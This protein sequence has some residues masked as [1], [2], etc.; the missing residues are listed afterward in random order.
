MI[1]AQIVILSGGAGTR[2]WPLSREA[3]PKQFHDFTGS[4][5][6]L[7]V[8]TLQ[9]LSA[10][11]RASV[12]TTAALGPATMGL[13]NRHGLHAQ[14]VGEPE[15]KNT[16]P[17]VLL[18]SILA[19][20]AQPASLVGV[21]PADHLIA[22]SQRFLEILNRGFEEAAKGR[23]VT[24]G[25]H[26]E[27]PSCAYG[28]IDLDGETEDRGVFRVN[29]FIE[30]PTVEK[31]EE[32]IRTRRVVWNAGMFLFRSDVMIDLFRQHE[33]KMTEALLC[34]RDDLSNLKEI[35]ASLKGNS[36]DYAVMEKLPDILCLPAD[37]GWSDIGSWEEVSRRTP[38]MGNPIE[39]G[40]EGNFFTGLANADKRV[41]F[42]GV[43]DLVAIDTPDAILIARQGHGQ[44]VRA[45][46]DALRKEGSTLTKSHSFEDRPWGRFEVLMDTPYFKSK[47]ITVMPGQKLSYQSHAKRAEHWIVVRGQA[48]VTLNDQVLNLVPGEHV[49]IPLGAKHRMANPGAEP[50]EFIEVQTGTYFGEDDIVRYSDAYGRSS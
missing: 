31:A 36:I 22:N 48:Q 33:P 8:E 21:F 50:M 37:I 11:Q 46:V 26:P 18:A 4:G 12:V 5:K 40:G 14:V 49:H 23:V 7:L 39:V 13:L 28:Y 41:V 24:L 45:A 17:A 44:E 30:K 10:F 29:R 19:E 27:S 9:R 2:L 43:S 6:P 20:R 15:P 25:I 35:Y 34:V 16:A 32:L 38:C 42:V 47:R 1:D 3:Y